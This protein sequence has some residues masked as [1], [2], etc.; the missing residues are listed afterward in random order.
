M[1]MKRK[2]C[3]D[4]LYLVVN[5]AWEEPLSKAK[6]FRIANQVEWDAYKKVRMTCPSDPGYLSAKEL[7]NP[8]PAPPIL[9]SREKLRSFARFTTLT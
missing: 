4:Q 8:G 9:L 2:G 1:G 5:Q 6:P 7:K 3:V